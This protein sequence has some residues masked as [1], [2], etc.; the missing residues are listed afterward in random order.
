MKRSDS[1]SVAVGPV[2]GRKSPVN[3]PLTSR[4][5]FT[6]GENQYS[7]ACNDFEKQIHSVNSEVR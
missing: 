7:G 3:D 1:P 5:T 4:G 6:H 2:S